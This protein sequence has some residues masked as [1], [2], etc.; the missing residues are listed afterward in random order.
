MR[1]PIPPEG[2][3]LATPAPDVFVRVEADGAA[4][5]I[6]VTPDP[7]E[8]ACECASVDRSVPWLTGRDAHGNSEWAHRA[9]GG[10]LF[11]FVR[12]LPDSE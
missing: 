9:P 11:L 6:T 1:Y 3:T 5:V 7:Y 10:G 2:I 8:S 4:S 12:M